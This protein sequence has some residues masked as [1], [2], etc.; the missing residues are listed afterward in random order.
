[1]IRKKWIKILLCLLVFNNFL[2]AESFSEN[3]ENLCGNECSDKLIVVSETDKKNSKENFGQESKD[4][5]DSKDT[6]VKGEDKKSKKV[7]KNKKDSLETDKKSEE[8]FVVNNEIDTVPEI[9]K[10]IGIAFGGGSAKGL[11]HIG[12]LK[13][14]EE[15]K[16]PIEYVTGTSMGSIIGGLYA[17][18]Y[19]AKELEDIAVHM[20]W[21]GLFNDKIDRE[22]KGIVRNMIEDR[23]TLS[24]PMEKFMPKI[25]PG[26]IGG[27]SA[28]ERLNE[29]LYG[30]LDKNDFTKYPKKFAAVGTDLNTGEGVMI[31]KGSLATAIRSSLSLPSI[32]NPMQVGDKLYIDG[33]VVRNLPVQDLKVLGADYTIGINVGSG[34]EKRDLNKMTLVDVVSDAMTI[35]GRQEVERQ[36]RMLDMYM[37]PDLSKVEA[38]DFLKAKDIIAMGEKLARDHIDEIRKLSN[39]KKFDEIEEKRKEFRKTW[40]NEYDIKSVEIRGNKKYET[41]YFKRY[42]PE[43]LGKMNEKELESIVDNLYK[44][45]DFSTVY[46][47]IADGD[48]LVINVQE[49]AG[50]YLTFSSNA[51]TEDLATITVGIQ[52]NKTLVG[53]L[54]TRYQLKGII[55][56]EYGING[57]G[58][59]LFGKSNK[60]LGVTDFE[61]KRDKIK[62]Q[63]FMNEKYDFENQKFRVG[64]GLG[65]E[66]NTNT[67]FLIGGGYQISDVNKSLDKN[68]NKKIKF[69]YFETSLTHDSRDAINF[70]TKGSYFKADYIKGS[71]KEAKFDTLY[72]KGEVNIPFGKKVTVTPSITYVTTDGDKVPETY[73]PKLGGFS[74]SDYSME[75]GG[76]PVDKL[77]GSSIFIGKLNLQYQINKFIFAGINGS[78]AR[79]SDKGF[80]FGKEQK[81]NYSLGVGARLPI[82]PIYF[83]LAKSPGEGVRYI[84]NIGY[85]PK[86]F[87]EN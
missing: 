28:S 43:K 73:R 85:E 86:A 40:K 50:D 25:T 42:L 76:I 2:L 66:L 87:N 26:A 67:L 18:G 59:V 61:Y 22:K 47:E 41:E 69:P 68:M 57:A 65:V 32:Y 39:P 24:L 23:N 78:I 84:F 60:L 58:T 75:F 83:G 37:A 35:A 15:E 20:D 29:L 1:M 80:D 6:K 72:A 36:I 54:D 64:L 30:V 8:K 48:K 11:A 77:S 33:G 79:I 53:T 55:A 31:T 5:K 17:A 62:N 38:Y 7:S 4:E 52:G 49:K 34:F 70:A 74:E 81:E 12:I 45:G 9:D 14:L 3:N 27:K 10:K 21:M 44:N 82:G 16:V 71:S 46:Y 19:T 51:N 63:Y 13:V 56:D